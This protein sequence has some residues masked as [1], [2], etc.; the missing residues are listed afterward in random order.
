MKFSL[1]DLF[2]LI[3]IICVVMGATA[4]FLGVSQYVGPVGVFLTWFPWPLF[5]AA[6]GQLL[7][8]AERGFWLGLAMEVFFLL[9]AVRL[10]ILF[11]EAR[12]AAFGIP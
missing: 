10:Y 2:W 6:V 12:E 11:R 8:K 5:G 1:K 3:T 7:H 4:G 9:D